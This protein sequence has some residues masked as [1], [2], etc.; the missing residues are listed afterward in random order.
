MRST[1]MVVNTT[2]KN[3]IWSLTTLVIIFLI[4]YGTVIAYDEVSQRFKPKIKVKSKPVSPVE[5]LFVKTA[6]LEEKAVFNASWVNPN[7]TILIQP[8]VS[9]RLTR[10]AL[11]DGTPVVEGVKVKKGDLIATLDD[12]EYTADVE[13]ACAL[14]LSARVAVELA[15]VNLFDANREKE[16]QQRLALASASTAQDLDKAN[17]DFDRASAQY[18]Q[19]LS[20]VEESEAV[21]KQR[22]IK[23]DETKIYAP[24]SGVISKKLFHIGSY[25]TP[26]N[27]L[28]EMMDVDTVKIMISPPQQY[29]AK[30]QLDKTRVRLHSES[31]DQPRYG[32]V[33][34][35]HPAIDPT[36][37]RGRIEI[38][39]PNEMVNG[40][41]L[42][43]PGMYISAAII[44]SER[45]QVIAIPMDIVIRDVNRYLVYKL[46]GD[47]VS[48]VDVKLGV[49]DGGL[50]EIVSGLRLGDEIV[51][52]GQHRLTDGAQ[53]R[54][55]NASN[56][57]TPGR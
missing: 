5:T 23:L 19:A 56:T 2:A 8:K 12:A 39:V 49:N 55:V 22:Q 48:T 32:T 1:K 26:A 40:A 24:L 21:L 42:F 52:R 41:L 45:P 20:S 47:T 16:R 13:H 44:L 33:S 34:R 7:F 29:M 43:R 11:D 17:S 10:L 35:I 9:G 25:L 28:V 27:A 36:T 53:I 38:Y 3:W 51:C 14:L 50:V 37:R 46:D 6:D 4:G 57:S 15:R 54:R 18:K 31:F 30:I